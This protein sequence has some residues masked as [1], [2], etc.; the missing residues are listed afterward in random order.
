MRYVGR[1]VDVIGC[2]HV[3]VLLQA[4]AEEHLCLSLYQVD[5]RLDPA[6]QRSLRSSTFRKDDNLHAD[7][8]RAYCLAAESTQVS[9]ALLTLV[10]ITGAK[11]PASA[12]NTVHWRPPGAQVGVLSIGSPVW[13]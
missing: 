5:R 6:V 4:V 8:F 3:D 10:G 12:G 13:S 11:H 9:K 7:G 2:G 1:D